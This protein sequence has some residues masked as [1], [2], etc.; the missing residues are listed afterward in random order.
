MSGALSV[1]VLEIGIDTFEYLI[2]KSF[3]R[4]VAEYEPEGNTLDSKTLDEDKLDE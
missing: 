1:D 3:T 2:I 4:T